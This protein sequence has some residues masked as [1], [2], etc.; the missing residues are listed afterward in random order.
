M[1]GSAGNRA[2]FDNPEVDKLLEAGREES[3]TEKRREIYKQVDEILVEEQPSIFIRQAAS[4]HT[5]RSEV[6]NLDKGHLAKP[7]FRT[8]T[9][10]E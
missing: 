9:L 5:A 2:F 3:D 6:G 10:E 4:A 7:D 1:K 8:V